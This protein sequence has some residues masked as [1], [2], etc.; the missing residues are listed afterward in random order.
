MPSSVSDGSRPSA[1]RSRRYSSGESPCSATSSGVITKSD[2]GMREERIEDISGYSGK[3]YSWRLSAS[4]SSGEPFHQPFEHLGAI[5]AGK[6]RIGEA[7]GV[8]HHAEHG[9]ALVV[10]TGDVVA[11]GIGIGLRHDTALRIAVAERHAAF[12]FQPLQSLV[13]GEIAAVLVGD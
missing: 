12:V 3:A 10:D 11:G 8:R 9:S 5:G 4:P 1:S 7:L 2:F 13:I 6:Q